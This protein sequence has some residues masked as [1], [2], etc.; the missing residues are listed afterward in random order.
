MWQ[1]NKCCHHMVNRDKTELTSALEGLRNRIGTGNQNSRNH[2]ERNKDRTSIAGTISQEQKRH[3]RK[4]MRLGNSF[5]TLL[6]LMHA[7]AVL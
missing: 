1:D 6:V 7:H 2:L 4:Q 3:W 5:E